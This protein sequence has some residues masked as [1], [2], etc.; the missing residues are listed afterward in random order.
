MTEAARP[1]TPVQKM[2]AL[3]TAAS[4]STGSLVCDEECRS[5]AELTQSCKMVRFF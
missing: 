1:Y 3:E 2:L 5:S 4:E